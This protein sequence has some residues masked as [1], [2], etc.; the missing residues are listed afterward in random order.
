MS[1]YAGPEDYWSQPPQGQY[2]FDASGGFGQ[3]NQQFEFQTYTEQQA[4]DYSSFNQKPYLDPTQNAYG[5]DMYAQDDFA[6][7]T[8]GFDEEDE[9]PLLEELG[10]DP[11]RII[12]KTLAVL[13]PFH[14]RGQTDD[15]NYLL[16]DSDLAGPVAFCLVLAAFL[17]LAGSKAHFGYVYG[18]A[19]T[20]C[21]MMYVLQSLMSS[22]GN[23][24]LSSVASVLGYCILPVVGLAG[25]SIFTTL[26][27]PIGMGLAAFAVTWATLSASRLFA[28]MSCEEK[29]R[30]LI[31]YPCILLYGVFT[32]IVIF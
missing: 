7:G 4:G 25:L 24:T 30:P 8:P 19:V 28:A 5:G 10:I 26:R 20:S 29:Q 18:L 15:A 22:T 12:Q 6:K 32:L 23:I 31:A 3:P 13:N 9:P 1:G 16:Q 11:D 14:R 27:G 21:L 2:N 17:L